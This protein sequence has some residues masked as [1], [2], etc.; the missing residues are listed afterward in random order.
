MIRLARFSKKL[1]SPFEENHMRVFT[2]VALLSLLMVAVSPVR[3]QSVSAAVDSV[4]VVADTA[5]PVRDSSVA[6][7]TLVAGAAA[8]GL[9]AGVHAR[10]TQRASEPTVTVA[11]SRRLGQARAMMV[12]GFGALLAGALIGGDPGTI[13]MVGG[14]VIGTIG[15]YEY[16]Q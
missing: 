15:L 4:R 10:E 3:A 8:N 6:S 7:P 1:A 9:R 2:P 13:I 14:A 16:V 11:R 12:V 5:K